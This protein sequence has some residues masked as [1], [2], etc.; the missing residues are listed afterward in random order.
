MAESIGTKKDF[1]T[2]LSTMTL[3]QLDA[4]VRGQKYRSR[5]EAIEAA[6]DRLYHDGEQALQ[7]KREALTQ[8]AGALGGGIDAGRWQ[9]AELDRLDWEAAR[10]AG[11]APSGD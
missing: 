3:S 9:R 8:S 4:L 5:T 1:A 7:R 11:R 2:R 6:V 10:T